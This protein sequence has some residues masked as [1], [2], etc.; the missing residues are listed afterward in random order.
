MTCFLVFVGESDLVDL[1]DILGDKE[2]QDILEV[3]IET[4]QYSDISDDDVDGTEGDDVDVSNDADGSEHDDVH[5]ESD[6]FDDP[7]SN[8][9]VS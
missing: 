7:E 1:K 3:K 9:D 5:E 2:I 8:D 6:E 4:G